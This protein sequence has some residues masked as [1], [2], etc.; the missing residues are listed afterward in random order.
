MNQIAARLKEF[1]VTLENQQL[2]RLVQ[3]ASILYSE[4]QKSFEEPIKVSLA[5]AYN[6][7]CC[8]L[9][10]CQYLGTFLLFL[11]PNHT[12]AYAEKSWANVHSR[13]DHE[14]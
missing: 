8:Y 12:S 14:A 11:S 5:Y 6:I 9:R 4:K 7:M 10:A 13:Y 3:R 1:E 2:D